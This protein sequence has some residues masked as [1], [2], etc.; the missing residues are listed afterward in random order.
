MIQLKKAIDQKRLDQIYDLY[1]SAFPKAER[2]PFTMLVKGQ[3]A[4]KMEILSIED[5]NETFLGLGIFALDQDLALVDYFAITDQKRGEGIG[6]QAL[7][8]LKSYYPDRRFFLEIET[9]KKDCPDL[10]TRRRRKKFYLKNGLHELPFCVNLFGVEMEI[11]GCCDQLTYEE[12]HSVYRN[13]CG[14]EL[15][16]KI[17]Q[18]C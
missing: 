18:I 10:E 13:T 11:L 1:V 5:E 6:S 17:H 16:R 3:N 14:E 7:Q 2:K 4:G 15:S 12:Y 8:C 9:T